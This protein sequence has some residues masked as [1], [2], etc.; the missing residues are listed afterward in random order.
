M[1]ALTLKE[2]DNIYLLRRTLKNKRLNIKTIRLSDKLNYL[3]LRLFKIK[4]K[5]SDVNYRLALLE[6]MK[7]Y[8]IFYVLL[9]EKA[10]DG[11][12]LNDEVEVESK[13]ED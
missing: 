5:L 8:P 6:I 11:I 9:L 4:K 13:E 2:G 7:I 1:S 12:P 3:K 10:S